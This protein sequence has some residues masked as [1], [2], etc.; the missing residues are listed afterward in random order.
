VLRAILEARRL[1]PVPKGQ[2]PQLNADV[3]S[4]RDP[5]ALVGEILRVGKKALLFRRREDAKPP[6]PLLF[7]VSDTLAEKLA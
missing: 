7:C 2:I 1:F 6:P 5:K 3:G 4:I